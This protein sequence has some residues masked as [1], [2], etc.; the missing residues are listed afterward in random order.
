[1]HRLKSVLNGYQRDLS[2][3]NEERGV[4][5]NVA[6]NKARG[7]GVKR[8][9]RDLAT[10]LFALRVLLSHCKTICRTEKVHVI[11]LYKQ[12]SLNTALFAS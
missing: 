7:L 3:T 10:W 11:S 4:E 1:M 5:M 9:I 2:S 6:L 12:L 8:G